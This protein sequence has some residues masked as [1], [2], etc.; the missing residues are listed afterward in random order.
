MLV[1]TSTLE[2]ELLTGNVTLQATDEFSDLIKLKFKKCAKQGEF[3]AISSSSNNNSLPIRS[4]RLPSNS[5]EQ[6]IKSG[7]LLKKRDIISGWKC[8][9]FE[10]FKG[11]LN[12]YSKENDTVPRGTISL[13]NAEIGPVRSFKIKKINEYWGFM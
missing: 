1:G 3:F 5:G 4:N 2:N 12:Y 8:R 13:E 11:K 7:W 10:V 6:P 9:Y